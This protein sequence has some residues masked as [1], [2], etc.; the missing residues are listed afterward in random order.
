MQKIYQELNNRFSWYKSWHEQP[1][2][3][4]LHWLT[5]LC[6]GII[7]LSAVFFQIKITFEPMEWVDLTFCHP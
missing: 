4:H 6:V 1:Y 3:P 2:H 7:T 5:F